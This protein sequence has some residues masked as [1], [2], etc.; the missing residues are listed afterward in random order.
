MK[1]LALSKY[2]EIVKPQYIFLK[3]TP[4]KSLRNYNS[5]KIINAV[6]TVYRHFTQ[7]LVKDKNKYFFTVQ[8]KLVYYDK[9]LY[10]K[11]G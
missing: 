2:F 10:M 7:R 3:L 9:G 4:L 6:S 1:S 5:D 11:K 8:C